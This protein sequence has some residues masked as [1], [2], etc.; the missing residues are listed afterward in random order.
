[1]SCVGATPL[2]HVRRDFEGATL[3]G[4]MVQP[5][6]AGKI[7]VLGIYEYLNYCFLIKGQTYISRG[8]MLVRCL[9]MC[10]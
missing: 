5:V 6:F 7:Q 4:G 1:M 2:S 10:T 3:A 9:G 8:L